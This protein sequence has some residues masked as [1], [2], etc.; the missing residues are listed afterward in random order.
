MSSS[1]SGPHRP[2]GRRWAPAL[3][4]CGVGLLWVGAVGV[5]LAG[6]LLTLIVVLL[7]IG[8]IA[9]PECSAGTASGKAW[10]RG[11]GAAVIIG[12]AAIWAVAAV[13]LTRR[14]PA[15]RMAAA[16]LPVWL[17][18]LYATRLAGALD[19]WLAQTGARDSAMNCF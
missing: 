5:L 16:V 4:T 14:A 13:G 3:R 8:A 15:V 11:G 12:A 7:A 19:A 18:P 17:V 10:V 2:L 6:A 1:S 9:M